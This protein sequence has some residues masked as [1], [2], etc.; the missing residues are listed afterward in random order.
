MCYNY[1]CYLEVGGVW[2]RLALRQV[3]TLLPSCHTFPTV[4]GGIMKELTN[5]KSYIQ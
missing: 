4:E 2:K 5:Q 3:N 1:V